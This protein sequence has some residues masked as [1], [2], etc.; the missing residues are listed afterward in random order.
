MGSRFSASLGFPHE[1][2]VASARGETR[3]RMVLSLE[4]LPWRTTHK[5]CIRVLLLTVGEF[6]FV[7]TYSARGDP[8]T[9]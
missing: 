5:A 9:V 1:A 3:R 7:R 2:T 6:T 8:G 4:V